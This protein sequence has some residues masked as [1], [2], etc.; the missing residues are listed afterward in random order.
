MKKYMKKFCK[1]I[2]P[3]QSPFKKGEDKGGKNPSLQASRLSIP[4]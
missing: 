1:K 3:P 2:K 4:L